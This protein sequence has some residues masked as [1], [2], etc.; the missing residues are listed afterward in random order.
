[1]KRY[2]KT[3]KEIPFKLPS[4]DKAIKDIQSTDDFKNCDFKYRIEYDR[5]D[6]SYLIWLA[7]YT[8]NIGSSEYYEYPFVSKIF[9]R[10]SEAVARDTGCE[11]FMFEP[12]NS[13]DFCGRVWVD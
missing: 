5:A 6:D 10:F 12:Y 9:D 2:I 11:D 13:V 8:E 1:M 4:L 7:D 3:N